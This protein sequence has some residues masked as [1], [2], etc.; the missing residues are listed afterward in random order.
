MRLHGDRATN[1]KILYFVYEFEKFCILALKAA[2]SN[3][4]NQSSNFHNFQKVSI[5]EQLL[6]LLRAVTSSMRMDTTLMGCLGF[7][8]V[9]V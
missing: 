2:F 9:A 4:L 8:L 6:Y 5:L 3:N 7:S 1:R